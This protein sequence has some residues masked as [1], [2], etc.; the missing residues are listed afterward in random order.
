MDS[1]LSKANL[2]SPT[3]ILREKNYYV[4]YAFDTKL[5][6]ATIHVS[7]KGFSYNISYDESSQVLFDS[8]NNVNYYCPE[9]CKEALANTILNAVCKDLRYPRKWV[10]FKVDG[11]P[12]KKLSFGT[13]K[14]KE[15][16]LH[17]NEMTTQ[18]INFGLQQEDW[19]MSKQLNIN[20]GLKA[21]MIAYYG[22]EASDA[23]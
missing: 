15:S 7:W 19:E 9:Y 2:K 17:L 20:E 12:A 4:E 16:V 1:K 3:E 18:I 21:F 22:I 6:T 10:L 23:K 14:N 8:Y 13:P 5:D 11:K